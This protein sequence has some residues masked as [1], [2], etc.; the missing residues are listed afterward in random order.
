[1]QYRATQRILLDGKE[2]PEGEIIDIPPEKAGQLLEVKAIELLPR[3]LNIDL[4]DFL[5]A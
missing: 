3:G 2:I 1:M 4:N 5:K